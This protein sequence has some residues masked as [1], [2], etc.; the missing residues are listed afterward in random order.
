LSWSVRLERD[1]VGHFAVEGARF[2]GW[3]DGWPV[4]DEELGELLKAGDV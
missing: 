4:T 1:A 2:D 3:L